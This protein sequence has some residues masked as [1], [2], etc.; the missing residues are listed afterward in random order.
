MTVS[1][2]VALET[3]LVAPNL[4]ELFDQKF[5]I[6]MKLPTYFSQSVRESLMFFV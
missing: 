2:S 6:T 1:A 5:G 4:S 3:Q